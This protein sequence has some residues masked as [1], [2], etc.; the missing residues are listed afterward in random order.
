LTEYLLLSANAPCHS[1]TAAQT[2]V[3]KLQPG[4]TERVILEF[5]LE[6]AVGRHNSQPWSA[7]DAQ[8]QKQGISIRQQTFQQG[9][10]KSSRG[11][12]VFIGSNDHGIGRGYFLIQDRE[13]AEV[14]RQWYVRR[15]QIKQGHLDQ[16]KTLIKQQWP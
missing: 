15:I 14:M 10:L 1:L 11:A 5:L 6:K 7:L 13:D 3:Q 2:Y 4:S 9:L 8:L 12:E 16:L